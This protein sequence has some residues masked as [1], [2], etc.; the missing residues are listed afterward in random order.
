M[1]QVNSNIKIHQIKSRYLTQNDF[2]NYLIVRGYNDNMFNSN[3]KLNPNYKSF[4]S[5]NTVS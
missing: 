5:K 2:R 4:K 1:K 3:K